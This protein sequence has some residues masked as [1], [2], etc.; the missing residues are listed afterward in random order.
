MTLY[1]ELSLATAIFEKSLV[2]MV[3][4]L[5]GTMTAENRSALS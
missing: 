1:Q 5:Y 3:G 4:V 2:I